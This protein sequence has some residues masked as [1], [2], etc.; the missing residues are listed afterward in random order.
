MKFQQHDD[1]KNIQ[2]PKKKDLDLTALNTLHNADLGVRV[3]I[4]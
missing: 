1:E 3:K 2:I 4:P